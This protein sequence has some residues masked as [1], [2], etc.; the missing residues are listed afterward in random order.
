MTIPIRMKNA[1]RSSPRGNQQKMLFGNPVWKALSANPL[2]EAEQID[3]SLITHSAFDDI[4]RGKG[5]ER[6][7]CSVSDRLLRRICIGK[8]GV[9]EGILRHNTPSSIRAYSMW[10]R[11]KS[12]SRIRFR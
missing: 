7:L 10:A 5:G 3:I 8:S 11:T 4:V 2:R 12:G 1:K 6:T 9:W